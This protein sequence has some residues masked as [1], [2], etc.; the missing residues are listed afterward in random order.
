MRCLRY[1]FILTG[2]DSMPYAIYTKAIP[3][4]EWPFIAWLCV[5]SPH[6]KFPLP[7]VRIFTTKRN[8]KIK[9]PQFLTQRMYREV[10]V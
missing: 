5:S 7:H 8:I 3:L 10:E 6:Y 1:S 9:L 2:H 4:I